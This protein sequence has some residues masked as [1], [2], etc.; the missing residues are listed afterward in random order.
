MQEEF[1]NVWNVSDKIDKDYKLLHLTN[2]GLERYNKHF[3]TICPNSHP[4]LVVFVH[5]LCKE[6]DRVVQQMDDLSKG[7]E[8]PPQYNE[9]GFPKIPADF[10]S[11][12]N[13]PKA[14]EQSCRQE[15]ESKE[16]CLVNVLLWFGLGSLGRLYVIVQFCQCFLLILW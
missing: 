14:K 7:R 11:D 10:Y 8:I 1:F 4:I 5:A 12:D 13:K 15:Q 16:G 6:A 2:N 3:N 9:P